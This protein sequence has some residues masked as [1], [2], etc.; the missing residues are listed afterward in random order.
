[1]TTST[2]T[3]STRRERPS[4]ALRADA[5]SGLPALDPDSGDVARRGA[6]GGPR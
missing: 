2:A 6:P 1:M 3:V 5:L 4:P